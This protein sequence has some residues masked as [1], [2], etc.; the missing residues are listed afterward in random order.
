MNIQWIFMVYHMYINIKKGTEQTHLYYS[1]YIPHI[2]IRSTYGFDIHGIYHVYTMYIPCIY[3]YTPY[4]Y[5][6]IYYKR[7]LSQDFEAPIVQTRLPLMAHLTMCQINP[8][9]LILI[10]LI[11]NQCWKHSCPSCRSRRMMNTGHYLS[12]STVFQTLPVLTL[13]NP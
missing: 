9:R 2:C 4:A 8:M 1:W 5:M 12:S 7:F 6:L 10:S 3:T 13:P 11:H